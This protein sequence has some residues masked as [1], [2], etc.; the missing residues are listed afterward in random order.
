M[1]Y[2]LLLI[3]LTTS[4]IASCKSQVET[5]NKLIDNL[6]EKELDS[7][8]ANLLNEQFEK[9][10]D[11]TELSIALVQNDTVSFFGGTKKEGQ[12]TPIKNELSLFEIGSISKVFTTHLLMEAVNNNQLS[13]EDSI[14]SFLEL[15]SVRIGQISL[16]QLA[17]HSSGLPNMP[18]SFFENLSDTLNPYKD[19]DSEKLLYDLD[20]EISVDEQMVDKFS[21]S[22]YGMSLLGHILSQVQEKTYQ[23]LLEAEILSPVGMTNT[24]TNIKESKENLVAGYANGDPAIP[25]EMKAITPAGGIISNSAD[26][27]KYINATWTQNSEIFINQTKFEIPRNKSLCQSL[28]WMKINS[29]SGKPYYFHS[30]RTGAYS[31][32]IIIKPSSKKG[33]IILSN[34]SEDNNNLDNLGFKLMKKFVEMD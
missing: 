34:I 24:F 6:I 5:P 23:D 31:S 1:K 16:S 25:W 2:R 14:S 29:K 17:S 12:V 32:I 3:I 27:S 9:F 18:P 22:N 28:G 11:N 13:L 20:N 15:D 19:Y 21:Y 4:L 26:M 10:N 33:I 30:G 7:G 8:I